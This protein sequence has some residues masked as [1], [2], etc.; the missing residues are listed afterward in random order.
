MAQA[1]FKAGDLEQAQAEFGRVLDVTPFHVDS[2]AG[3]AEVYITLAD[4]RGESG[5]AS[6]DDLYQQAIELLKKALCFCQSDDS[7]KV[8]RA[9][10]R[11]RYHYLLGYAS[12]RRYEESSMFGVGDDLIGDALRAFRDSGSTALLS[13]DKQRAKR[14]EAR[15][16]DQIQRGAPRSRLERILPWLVSALALIIFTA[17]SVAVVTGRPV[18][19]ERLVLGEDAVTA[20][21]KQGLPDQILE[22]IG[23]IAGEPAPTSEALWIRLTKRAGNADLGNWKPLVMEHV[24]RDGGSLRWEQ[25]GLATYGLLAF[26]SLVLMVAGASLPYLRSLKVGQFQLEKGETERIEPIRSFGISR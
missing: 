19:V 17:S 10:D 6:R 12:T 5:G 1:R 9:D 8:Y 20:L 24:E 18:W 16:R 26:G 2:L 4:E 25:V 11:A 22:A 14:A 13:R 23:A 3:L 21:A 15:I 7:P